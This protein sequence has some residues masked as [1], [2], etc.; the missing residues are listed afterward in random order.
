[1]LL[2]TDQFEE[3]WLVTRAKWY[4]F[5]TGTIRS[6][7]LLKKDTLI[8]LEATSRLRGIKFAKYDK[9]KG[10]YN[11]NIDEHERTKASL[12]EYSLHVHFICEFV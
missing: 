7:T 6:F 1:M 3:G 4:T 2:E 5:V 12:Q 10:R 8:P 9:T 11:L